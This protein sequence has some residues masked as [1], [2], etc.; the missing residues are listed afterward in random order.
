MM[1]KFAIGLLVGGLGGALLAT[2]NLKMRT[3][4][5]KGQD[6]IKAR[7]DELMD[8]K[9]REM[10][11]AEPFETMKET[12]ETVKETAQTVKERAKESVENVKEEAKDFANDVKT[13]VKGRKKATT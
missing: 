5:K 4:I 11:N 2:N 6:E 3:L 12:G 7:L 8:A 9:I 13:A 10:E 1:E